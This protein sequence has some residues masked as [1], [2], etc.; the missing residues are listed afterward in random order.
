M[1]LSINSGITVVEALVHRN[2]PNG[3]ILSYDVDNDRQ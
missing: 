3:G 2:D 1:V